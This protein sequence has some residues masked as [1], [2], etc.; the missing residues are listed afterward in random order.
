MNKS[1]ACAQVGGRVESLSHGGK[2]YELGASIIYNGNYYVVN[3]TDRYCRSSVLLCSDFALLEASSRNAGSFGVG[4]SLTSTV[5]AHRLGLQRQEV[6]AGLDVGANLLS[7]WNG[8][9]F[10]FRESSFSVLS[11]LKALYRWGTAPIRFKG[12]PEAFFRNFTKIYDYQAR[13]PIHAPLL[14]SVCSA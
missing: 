7:L 5:S 14:G 11:L 8:R 2:D 10:V 3:A 9:S 13:R 1:S 4:K 12:F 6:D